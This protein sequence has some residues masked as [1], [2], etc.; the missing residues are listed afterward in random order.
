MRALVTGGAGFIGSHLAEMLIAEGH[1]V[2]VIDNLGSGRLANLN[3]IATHPGFRF[4]EADVREM[5]SIM[6]AFD[7][8]DWVF[9]L[10]GLA[11][12]RFWPIAVD[13]KY[14]ELSV[15]AL[16]DGFELGA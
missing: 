1:E 2:V 6:P 10:A 16:H 8:A 3:G 11:D 12:I 5:A 15:R 7:G 9:H 14:A 4:V 13:A